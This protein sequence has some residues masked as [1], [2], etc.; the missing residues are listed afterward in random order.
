MRNQTTTILR[1]VIPLFIFTALLLFFWRGLHLDPHQLPSALLNQP[2]PTFDLVTLENPQ[3]HLTQKTFLGQVSLLHVWATW[4]ETC[5]QEHPLLMDL[6]RQQTIPIYAFD[7][8]DNTAAAKKWLS[9]YGNPYRAI[10]FDHNGNVSIDWGVYGTPETFVID[11]QGV[12][13][14]KVIGPLTRAVWQQS[15]APLLKQLAANA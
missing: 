12:I 15:I 7:Y 14:Y 10:G 13:R 9:Q 5:Q 11:R 4:C 1:C 2:A 6:A 3:Q 8:K